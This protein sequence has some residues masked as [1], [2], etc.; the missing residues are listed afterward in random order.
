MNRWLTLGASLGAA[1]LLSG[2]T[3]ADD[4]KSGPQPGG[5]CVPF[6]PLHVNGPTEGKKLCLV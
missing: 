3:A 5:K 6:N 2:P 1:L 4:L